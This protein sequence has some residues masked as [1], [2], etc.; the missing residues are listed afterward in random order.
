MSLVKA[1]LLF[2]GL[3][4]LGSTCVHFGIDGPSGE[5]THLG[6]AFL[7]SIFFALAGGIVLILLVR[8]GLL[9]IDSL[10]FPGNSETTPP[11]LYKLPEWYI[12]EGR[13][14]EALT[15]YEKISKIHPRDLTCWLGMLDVLITHMGNIPAGRK[16]ARRGLRKLKSSEE[17]QQLQN[18][19]LTLTGEHLKPSLFF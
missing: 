15:E 8:A 11:A 12:S 10:L 2:L 16:A 6:L 19:Y 1:L 9:A 5:V 18:H 7:G 17:K 14:G 13:F 4:L 3:L